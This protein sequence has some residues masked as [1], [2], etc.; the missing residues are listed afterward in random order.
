MQ[1]KLGTL[2]LEAQSKLEKDTAKK[3][4]KAEAKAEAAE[5]K[6]M[7]R[8]R[9]LLLVTL[10]Q[11]TVLV[12]ITSTLSFTSSPMYAETTALQVIIKRIERTKR[13]HVTAIQGLEAFGT[14]SSTFSSS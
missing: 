2:S 6:K 5:K 13:K 10:T 4:A 12:G 14:L 8:P 11:S 9:L 7:V 1:A 3:E